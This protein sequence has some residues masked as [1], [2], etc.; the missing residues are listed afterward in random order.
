MDLVI[1]KEIQ[2]KQKKILEAKA[3]LFSVDKDEKNS[4]ERIKKR[5][6]KKKQNTVVDGG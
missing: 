2:E 4:L 5:N 6:K 1:D 3:R